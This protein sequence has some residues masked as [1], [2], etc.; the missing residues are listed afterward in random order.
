MRIGARWC[1]RHTSPRAGSIP[2]SAALTS[3]I[4]GRFSLFRNEVSKADLYVG[5]E[6]RCRAAALDRWTVATDCN[7]VKRDEP[8]SAGHG[9]HRSDSCALSLPIT[10]NRLV[11]AK[12]DSFE[13]Q[14]SRVDPLPRLAAPSGRRRHEREM[15]AVAVAGPERLAFGPHRPAKLLRARAARMKLAAG[16]PAGE[17]GD[18]A[19]QLHI[20]APTVGVGNRLCGE[21][22]VGIGMSR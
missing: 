15:A 19:L 22:A 11:H 17:A 18:L 6:S 21:Q 9:V 10:R 13:F 8:I 5:T 20:V 3:F 12:C 14:I 2:A 16:R 7:H 4:W 1:G